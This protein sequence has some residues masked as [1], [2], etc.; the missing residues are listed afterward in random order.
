MTHLLKHKERQYVPLFGQ[1]M[2]HQL[3]MYFHL[4]YQVVCV[5]HLVY[6]E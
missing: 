6:E 5:A 4:F 3:I 1:C 2:I